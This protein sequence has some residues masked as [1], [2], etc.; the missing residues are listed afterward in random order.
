MTGS[1]TGT[2]AKT[3]QTNIFLLFHGTFRAELLPFYLNKVIRLFSTTFTFIH[4]PSLSW[5]Y[6]R[7]DINTG[8]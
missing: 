4:F 5:Y 1:D 2:V 3:I 8:R 7:F 6:G